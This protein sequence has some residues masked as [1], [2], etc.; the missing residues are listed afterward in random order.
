MDETIDVVA[1]GVGGGGSRSVFGYSAKDVVGEAYVE[2]VGAAGQDVDL[3]MVLA[4][5]HCG[6]ISKGKSNCNRR[7][8]RFAAE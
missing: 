6:R 2:F 3:K 1:G 4:K 8:L 5:R 7:F